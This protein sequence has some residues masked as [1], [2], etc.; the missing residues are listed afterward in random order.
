[1]ARAVALAARALGRTHPN[2]AVGAVVVR[3]GR[4]VGEG[5]TAPVGGPHAEVTALRRAGA[6]ARGADLYVTLEPCPHFGRTPPCVDAV[7][8]AGIRRVVVATVDPNRR[9][10]G[11]GIHRLCAAGIA[12]DVGVG[13]AEATALLAG[14]RSLV[15]R[16]RPLVTL[17][18]A[19][20]LDGRIATRTGD[21]RWITGPAA[22]RRG[23]ALRNVHDAVLVG[24]GTVRTDAPR[25]TCRLR[26][27]RN[28]VRVVVAGAALD[29]PRRAP[30]LD[31]RAAP[32]WVVAP[33]SARRRAV[34]ALRARGVDVLLLPARDGRI[35]FG[36]VVGALGAR[37]ITSVLVEGGARV[38]ADA[39]ASG[40][41][42]VVVW[43]VAPSLLGGDAVPAIGALG[44]GRARAALRLHD[45]RVAR[46]GADLVLT[47]SGRDARGSSPFAS[48]WPAR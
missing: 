9:V 16:G 17:K 1:M 33:R 20:T 30:V 32:T 15:L 29:L 36:R 44:I 43:F 4:V 27:G 39:I 31:A 5:F 14:Y 24:A 26:G 28:P 21:A 37:G 13:A 48:G 23:H 45:V 38:A 3:G 12:V 41:V 42:D 34:A 18:L 8:A 46:L 35:P 11:R 19:A 7:V 2:P 10:R 25:L 6:R 40:V 22:R 47:A